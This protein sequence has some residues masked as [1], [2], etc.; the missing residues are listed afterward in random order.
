MPFWLEHDTGTEP[1]RRVVVGKLTGYAHLAGTRHGFPVLFWL[2]APARESN[3]HRAMAEAGI[4]PGVLVATGTPEHGHPAGPVWQ[5]PGRAGR[6]SLAELP[7][8]D[9]PEA[10]ASWDE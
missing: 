4:P 10:G 1:L 7:A 9:R 8:P 5:L 6:V 2:P 3:L